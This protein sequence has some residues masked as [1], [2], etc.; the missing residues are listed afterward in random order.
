V[1]APQ[2]VQEQRLIELLRRQ[3]GAQIL[4]AIEDPRVTEIIVNQDG[5]VWFEAYGKGMYEAGLHLVPSQVES[6]I[7]TV[8]ASLGIVANAGNPIVEG[9]LLIGGIRFEGL[10]AP[11]VPKPCC[12]MR[13]PAPVELTRFRRRCWGESKKENLN[14]RNSSAIFKGVPAAHRGTGACRAQRQ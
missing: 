13:K 3:L 7:G 1:N 12:V 8:A 6:L 14:A 10:L 5:R 2:H 9:E 4:A 11:V